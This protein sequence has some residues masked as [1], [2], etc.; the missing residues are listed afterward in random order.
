M[1]PA[2]RQGDGWTP[3]A[4]TGWVVL[5]GDPV[6]HSLSPTIHN[7]AFRA[8]DLDLVYLAC[9]V[10]PEALAAA[11][12][13]LWL[14]GAT[15]ANVTLPHKQT[16][17]ALA[18]TA[19]DT[20][21]A[22]GA[23]N[24]LRRGDAGWHADNTDVAGFLAPLAAHR[25]R[26]AGAS[27][28]VLGAGGAAR[29]VVYALDRLGLGR[30]TVVAR[31]PEQAQTLL[32]ELGVEGDV[33]TGAGARSHVRHA[34]LV[35]NATPLGMDGTSTPWPAT[36]DLGPGQIVYD[37]VYRPAVTPL[38]E[39]ARRHGAIGIGG[40]PMLLGQAADAYRQ[41]TGRPFPTAVAERA[42]AQALR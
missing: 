29:A 39:A 35:V 32:A 28:V 16:A 6:E 17:L 33:Q 1:I 26:L 41:W 22:L 40:L 21:Q 31:R 18:A 19:S 14:L 7:A 24:T 2:H 10:A 36:S 9:R 20:A 34:T 23:A 25:Q 11:M 30:T 38:L 5:L 27:A 4:S 13:G 15:G 8:H 37:L 3:S 12:Q 42:A